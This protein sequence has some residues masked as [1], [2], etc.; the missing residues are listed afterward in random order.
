MAE[1][2]EEYIKTLE[3]FKGLLRTYF[4]SKS[5]AILKARTR[6]SIN[7]T[8][9]RVEKILIKAGVAK[10]MHI[11]PPRFGGGVAY[12]NVNP[13]NIIFNAPYG[14]NIGRAIVDMIDEGIGVIKTLDNFSLGTFSKKAISGNV[15]GEDLGNKSVF[16]VHGHDK[17]L[18]EEV[19]R[20]VEKIGLSSIVLHERPNEGMTIIEKFE[21]HSKTSFAIVLMSPD[22]AGN[23]VN[24]LP[25]LNG[26]ARQNVIFE[27]GY[28]FG[29]LGRKNVCA[30]VKGSIEK[31]S[32]S[33]GIL[34]IPYGTTD[35]WKLLLVRELKAAKLNFDSNAF[36]Q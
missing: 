10:R 24:R 36:F 11:T 31:A 2:N 14:V 13:F 27:L 22:D 7:Q 33:D 30:I 6:T 28:F 9:V 32:D 1:K 29:K 16:I 18:K 8:K 3:E 20:F 35:D 25:S 26:R 34:Y 15:K 4:S 21:K 12:K 17:A 19:A 23:S 5:S